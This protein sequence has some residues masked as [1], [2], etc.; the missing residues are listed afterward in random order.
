MNCYESHRW[1]SYFW[2]FAVYNICVLHLNLDFGLSRIEKSSFEMVTTPNS[3][4][5]KDMSASQPFPNKYVCLFFAIAFSLFTVTRN[6]RKVI[7]SEDTKYLCAI[8]TV[9]TKSTQTAQ[10]TNT[11]R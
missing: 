5:Q 7:S 6:N 10:Q 3:T 1:S 2:S 8:C 11:K 9:N 4:L